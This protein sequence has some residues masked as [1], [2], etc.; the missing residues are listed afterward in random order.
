MRNNVEVQIVSDLDSV[1]EPLKLVQWAECV[2]DGRMEHVEMAIRVVDLKES[3]DLNA[4]YR[5]MPG[6]TN[7]LSFS[8][9]PFDG[10][11]IH[12]L[13][14]LVICAPV[15]EREA[16]EQRKTAEAHWAHMVVH[17]V[18]HL[19]GYDHVDAEQAIA[20]EAEEKKLLD[21]IGFANPYQEAVVS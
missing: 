1:P 12:Q 10:I 8:C 3:A 7:V 6:A 17:G 4:R 21:L 20:M 13:G 2:L 11:P 14:D 5:K 19:L 16:G 18:L 9:E 15:V